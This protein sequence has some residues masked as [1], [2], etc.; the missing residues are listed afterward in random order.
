MDMEGTY[1]V[2]LGSEKRGTVTVTAQGLYWIIRCS[3][4]L[5]SQVMQELVAQV[6][7]R[8][9]K[10]G[11]LVPEGEVY[12]LHTRI[13]RKELPQW[14]G[15]A[16]QPRH[17]KLEEGF[18]PVHPEEPFAYLH[19]LEDAYLARKEGKLGLMLTIKK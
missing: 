5:Y 8:R 18:Y 7:H 19:R 10:L 9:V 16:L 13:S 12:C 2:M 14:D 11:L 3:C 4:R 17:S 1:D 6:G 15:F